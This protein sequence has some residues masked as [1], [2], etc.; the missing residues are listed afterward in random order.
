MTSETT[1]QEL[2]AQE[3][4]LIE[5]GAAF[6]RLAGLDGRASSHGTV[7]AGSRGPYVHTPE[8]ERCEVIVI[9]GGQAGL[10]VGHHLAQ[11][12]RRFVIL[13]AEARVGDVWRRRWDSLR[14]FT[15]RHLDGL[16]GLRFPGPRD[17]F[18]TKD[19]MADYLE[20]YAEHFA[21]PVRSRAKVDKVEQRDGRYLVTAGARRFEAEQ[22]VV[23]IGSYQEPRVPAFARELDPSIVQLHSSEYRSPSQLR[24]GAVLIVGAGNSGA[25]VA[26]DLAKQHPIYL[27]GRNTGEVPFRITGWLGRNILCRL[28]L[29]LVFHRV[30]TM[31]NP[32][33]R[34]ARPKI[35]GRGAPLIR[36]KHEQLRAAGVEHTA[37]VAAVRNGKPVLEDGR[38]LDVANVVWCT[39]FHPSLSF[40][41][42]PILDEHGEPRHTSGVVEQAPG[43]Y[44]VGLHFLHAMSSSMIHGVGR[45]AAR[46]A[47]L[48]RDRI[49]SS[50]V[51]R[52][53]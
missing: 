36:T 14:L 1:R 44:F 46:I 49:A 7:P 22:V 12:G 8:P 10:T 18:P 25:E 17:T 41:D 43:L 11:Q 21:L 20:S 15:P 24:A 23:A 47:G 6:M 42:L 29:R 35:V 51:Q 9:G 2:R 31:N 50:N 16:D 28:L 48:I 34:K 27:A 19:E 5:E 4:V 53:R 52:S 33:G 26:M 39:G 40:I 37:R 38:T 32:I 13:D 30:L 45:D 3:D